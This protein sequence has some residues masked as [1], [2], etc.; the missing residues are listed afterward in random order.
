MGEPWIIRTKSLAPCG[1]R[2]SM[3]KRGGCLIWRQDVEVTV[4][5]SEAEL[6]KGSD[7]DL[8]LRVSPVE[9]PDRV[10]A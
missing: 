3:R 1:S 7:G 9:G 2:P 6:Y 5:A 4:P 10:S 8:R